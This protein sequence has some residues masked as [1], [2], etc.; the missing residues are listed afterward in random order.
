MHG[1]WSQVDTFYAD[2]SHPTIS[3]SID[4][5]FQITHPSGFTLMGFHTFLPD[6]TIP[7]AWHLYP[8]TGGG[9]TAAVTT[10]RDTI[11]V[12]PFDSVGTYRIFLHTQQGFPALNQCYP[13][14]TSP[15]ISYKDTI[16]LQVYPPINPY[17]TTTGGSLSI[18]PNPTPGPS[19][20]L[21]SDVP[22]VYLWCINSMGQVLHSQPLHKHWEYD[23]SLKDLPQGLYF[24]QIQTTEGY[25]QQSFYRQ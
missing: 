1:Q 23:W 21:S 7:N 2:P 6:S 19:V 22:M 3:D 17:Q 20:R 5:I 24:I 11:R 4:L 9:H 14:G 25:R 18:F 13:L 15:N 8:C 10:V 12:A 16:T